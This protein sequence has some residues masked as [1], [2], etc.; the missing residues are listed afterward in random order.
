MW[1]TFGRICGFGAV[2]N[3]DKGEFGQYFCSSCFVYHKWES[4]V[5]LKN[6]FFVKNRG[7]G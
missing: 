3:V 6:E 7:I 1:I 4:Y 5:I 2:D